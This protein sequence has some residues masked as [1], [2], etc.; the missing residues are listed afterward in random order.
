MK[1]SVSLLVVL[2]MIVTTFAG[3]ATVAAQDEFVINF[4]A[5]FGIGAIAATPTAQEHTF[6]YTKGASATAGG[7]FGGAFPDGTTMVYTVNGGAEQAAGTS[8]AEP[9]VQGA[10]KATVPDA[11]VFYRFS[12]DLTQTLNDTYQDGQE[13]SVEIF[14]KK[15]DGDRILLATF[16]TDLSKKV[17]LDKALFY[18]G[19]PITVTYN[20]ADAENNDW[21]CIYKEP[22]EGQEYGPQPNDYV[23][24]QYA[25]VDGS[26]KVVFNDPQNAVEGNDRTAVPIGQDD[27]S[28]NIIVYNKESISMLAPGKYH[29]VILG[30]ESWYDVECEKVEFE[31]IAKDLITAENGDYTV[32]LSLLEGV[33]SNWASHGYPDRTMR[34]LGYNNSWPI[35]LFDLTGFEAVEVTYATDMGFKAK[36]ASMTLTSCF[37]LMSENVTIGCADQPAYS[38]PDKIIA[39]ANCTDA[40]V[41]NPDAAGWAQGE[42]T[43][44]IDV[45]ESTYQGPIALSHFNS[46]GNEAL[47]VGIKF[48]AKKAPVEKT[49]SM[50]KTAYEVGEPIRISY[51]GADRANADWL[52][53]YAGA[54]STYGEQGGPISV[55][56]A[57]IGGDGTIVFNDPQNQV[58]GNDR[59][60]TSSELD[61]AYNETDKIFFQVGKDTPLPVLPEGTYHAVILGGESWYNVESE[62]IVF[63]V[64]DTSAKPGFAL[65]NTEGTIGDTVEVVLTLNNNPGISYFKVQIGYDAQKLAFKEIKTNTNFSLTPGNPEKNPY[66][67][68]FAAAG[69]MNQNPPVNGEVCVLVFDILDK[70][71]SIG[72]SALD[73]IVVE[74]NSSDTPGE[75]ITITD[76]FIGTDGSVEIKDVDCEH[77]FTITKVD[78]NQHKKVCSICEREYFEAHAWDEGKVTKE[79]SCTEAGVKTYSCP[80]C[81]GTKT[82]TIAAL[83]HDW[84]AGTVT[85]EPSCTEAGVKTYSCSRCEE[86]KTEEIAALGHSFTNYVYNND[87]TTAK[88]GTETAECDHGCGATDTRTKEGTKLPDENPPTGDSGWWIAGI[89]IAAAAGTV[90]LLFYR[91]KAIG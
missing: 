34:N 8:N 33:S 20:N 55:Q 49:I 56:Y 80:V 13:Q 12:M 1:R 59:T 28:Q 58:E 66:S 37:A 87:A 4:D 17:S 48:I 67:V 38:N 74:V 21:L 2:A 77:D 18:E 31:V 22:E 61:T 84:D 26:G 76:Q 42:R 15:P 82:E 64:E 43:A 19:D 10:V 85:K 52:C 23:S 7:W 71:S 45:S 83:E 32:N 72:T 53:I 27:Y 86:T 91:K 47:V 88:D 69:G 75:I 89:A 6:F 63:T 44:V 78:D 90:A 41:L 68:V 25:Y 46:T 30:G 40:S 57:Y 54:D 14:A 51:T 65:E 39:L 62:K 36:Q 9:A 11:T 81:G 50:E 73:L 35:G 70:T 16:R 60:A 5:A 3:F 24:E 29:A 79:P